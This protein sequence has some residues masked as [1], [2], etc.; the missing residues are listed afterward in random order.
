MSQENLE[1]LRRAYEAFNDGDPSVFL[2][3]YDPDI[4]LW[5]GPHSI[6]AGTVLGAATVEQ[7]F[8]EYFAPFGSSL[9]IDIEEF[10][11]VGDSVVVLTIERARGRRSGAEITSRQHPIVYT[12]RAGKIIRI[13]LHAS[14]A[15][16]LEAVGLSEQDA[17]ADS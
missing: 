6:E 10:V 5:V 4:V 11:E 14:R 8:T 3:H 9:R 15:E 7:W 1:L 2:D 17:H 12:L 13:D 16:A